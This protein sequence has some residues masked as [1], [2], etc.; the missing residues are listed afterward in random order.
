MIKNQKGETS[1]LQTVLVA[2]LIVA[3]FFIGMLWTKV[4]F[5]EKGA[6]TTAL[7]ASPQAP[8]APVAGDPNAGQPDPSAPI[9]LAAV[10]DKDH[11]RGNKNAR[12]A[13]V[14]Y[15]DL[16][17]PFCKQFHATAKQMSEEY[18]DKVMWVYR[19]FPLDQLHPKARAESI[20]SECAT[21]LG[22]E[23]KFWAFIDKVYEITPANNG[24]DLNQL[25]TIA[26][27]IGLNVDQFKKCQDSKETEPR[28]TADSES[29]IKAGINGT[30]G[31]ILLDTKTGKTY[32]IPGAVPYPQLK[33][34]IDTFIAGLE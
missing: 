27:Q 15:S 4:R 34:M 31:N 20:A 10:T 12:V 6:G 22:G 18:G 23:D 29:G 14:E 28:V 13:M 2:G 9:E 16:E 11:I 7:G 19:H 1:L 24:L 5:Y 17:C 33:T 25:P 3:A 30:P 32:Q 8:A 26:G 21:K